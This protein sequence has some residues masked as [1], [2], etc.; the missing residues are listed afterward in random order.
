MSCFV[1][2]PSERDVESGSFRRL[3]VGKWDQLSEIIQIEIGGNTT[4]VAVE[5]ANSEAALWIVSPHILEDEAK[6]AKLFLE[7]GKKGVRVELAGIFLH[8][9]IT[10]TPGQ[11]QITRFLARY[12]YLK[13]VEHSIVAFTI[14]GSREYRVPS[15][16]KVWNWLQQRPDSNCCI[17]DAALEALGKDFLRL[18]AQGRLEPLV[19][20]IIRAQGILEPSLADDVRTAFQ[21][22]LLDDL[23]YEK[24]WLLA[25]PESKLAKAVQALLDADG[26]PQDGL[27]ALLKGFL[28]EARLYCEKSSR[29][30]SDSPGHD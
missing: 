5:N 18:M 28:S 23:Q 1:A 12:L 19:R 29:Q 10:N 30:T 2:I 15:L 25:D 26:Q 9:G 8:P 4:I 3:G 27:D 24:Q 20:M 22:R 7:S 21:T 6:G 17:D 13:P 11:E 16:G 14:S